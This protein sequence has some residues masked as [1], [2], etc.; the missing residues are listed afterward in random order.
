MNYKLLGIILSLFV[1][2]TVGCSTNNDRTND[3][4]DHQEHDNNENETIGSTT[5]PSTTPAVVSDLQVEGEIKDIYYAD[6]NKIL[7]SADKLYLYDVET[8][9]II[10]EAPQE[11]FDTER[12]WVVDSGYVAVREL[13]D[14]ENS[15]SMMT[16]G[17][18]SFNVTFYD[19]D[20]NIVS[21]VDLNQLLEDDD[22]LISTHA[23]S[24]SSTGIQ[25]AYATF[26]GLFIYDF[27]KETKTTIIDLTSEDTNERFG[28]VDIEQVGFTNEDKQIAFKAQSFDIPADPDKP[29]FDTCGIVH[30]NGSELLNQ[31]FDNYTCKRLIP[32]DRHVLFTEDPVVA[33]G[34]TLV[35]EIPNRHTKI[36]T[37]IEKAESGNIWGSDSGKLFATSISHE[38]GWIIRV[39]NTETGK[40][41]AEQQVSSDGEERYMSHDPMIKVI[42]GTKTIIV[43]LGAK[44]DDIETKMIINPF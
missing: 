15:R 38:S 37:L 3:S 29:S 11:S 24:F 1:L 27:E 10:V 43:L 28:I 8:E 22:M 26:S 25:V 40:L 34:Q 17:S 35:M 4:N 9:S 32:Y 5:S 36:H 39:Y 21:E 16:D 33:T 7:I 6:G 20:L 23:I 14:N 42:D 12:F 2:F 18:F 13:I 19:H 44:R 31:T 41:E 30:I